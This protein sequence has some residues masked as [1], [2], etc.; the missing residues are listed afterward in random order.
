MKMTAA[1]KALI[2][3]NRQLGGIESSVADMR[4][5]L[6]GNGQPGMTKRLTD[7]EHSHE[8]HLNQHKKEETRQG[9]SVDRKFAG[10]VAAIS[11][12]IAAI[13]A[14]IGPLVYALVKV[15]VATKWGVKL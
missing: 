12:G 14:V 2:D 10:V 13:G 9:K 7:L 5:A 11:A 3:I 6:F 15:Y 1:E 8:N 4:K